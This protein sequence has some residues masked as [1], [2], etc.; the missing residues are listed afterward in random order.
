MLNRHGVGVDIASDGSEGVQAALAS[1]YDLIFCDIQMPIMDGYEAVREIR[2]RDKMIPIIALSAHAMK[3]EYQ[4]A[5]AGGFTDYLTKPIDRSAL[6]QTLK[7]YETAS[8]NKA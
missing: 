7:K 2:K 6:F 4:R 3:E 8:L 1:R 5:L